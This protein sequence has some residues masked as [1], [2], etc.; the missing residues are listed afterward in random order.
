G[1]F[2][3]GNFL[4]NTRY[5]V[6]VRAG[7]PAEESFTLAEDTKRLVEFAPLP[8]RLYFPAFSTSQ[9]E[10]GRR[11]FELLALNVPQV[12]L[13]AKQLDRHTLIHALRGYGSYYKPRFEE[14]A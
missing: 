1:L 9:L 5:A 6:Q 8:P 4:L 11:Q 7:F 2:F 3:S 13:R 14:D 12:R 10:T